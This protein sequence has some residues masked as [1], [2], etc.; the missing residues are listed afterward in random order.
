MSNIEMAIQDLE[1]KRRLL[2]EAVTA[3]RA[4]Q[5]PVLGSVQPVVANER[6]E[7]ANAAG[8]KRQRTGAVQDAGA[9]EGGA[10]KSFALQE[11]GALQGSLCLRGCGGC[12]GS[13]RGRSWWRR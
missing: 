11:K 10:K 1:E 12:R 3:L 5:W 4:L 2:D 7:L 6:K 9:R 8:K 13:S